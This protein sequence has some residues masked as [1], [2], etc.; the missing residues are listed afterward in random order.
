MN[1]GDMIGHRYKIIRSLGEGGMAGPS[2]IP[3][4]PRRYRKPDK[5]LP[6]RPHQGSE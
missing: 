2:L 5:R 4:D 6:F 3:A 1:P